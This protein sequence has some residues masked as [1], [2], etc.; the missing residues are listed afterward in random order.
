MFRPLFSVHHAVSTYLR[1][2]GTEDNL[3]KYTE[4]HTI[5]IY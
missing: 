3:I 5:T 1:T 2:W 4:K